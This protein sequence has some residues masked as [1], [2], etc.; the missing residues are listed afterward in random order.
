MN[1]RNQKNILKKSAIIAVIVL[2]QLVAVSCKN[3]Q[4]KANEFVGSYNLS[5]PM[6]T[7]HV[8]TS[9]SAKLL[10]NNDI[11]IKF[12]TA[13]EYNEGNKEMFAQLMPNMMTDLFVKDA[14]AGDLLDEGV[15]FNI[16]FYS[17]DG[18]EFTALELD[19]KKKDEL[20]N[21]SA[22]KKTEAVGMNSNLSPQMREMLVMLN[23]SLPIEN[24][25][26]GTKIVKIDIDK[27]NVLV[28]NVEVHDS[29]S[30]LLKDDASKSLMKE[31]IMRSNDY[32]TLMNGVKRLGVSKIKYQYQ[33][34]KGK[35]ITEIFIDTN[36]M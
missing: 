26:E 6:I 7:N 34:S 27:D 20:L 5:A 9:T 35:K 2:F 4:Q 29:L 19:K 3:K 23:K 32:R 30:D 12:Y 22:A 25:A 18:Q 13:L 31:G 36:E 17:S 15:K 24:K 14:T 8:V 28:Y 10:P 1:S 11:E 33:D 21:P 16:F